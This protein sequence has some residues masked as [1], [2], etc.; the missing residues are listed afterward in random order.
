ML[1]QIEN[2]C[3][4]ITHL[5]VIVKLK[6]PNE[7]TL[8]S[9]IAHSYETLGTIR[10]YSIIFRVLWKII[11]NI[12]VSLKFD[13]QIWYISLNPKCITITIWAVRSNW[14]DSW[15]NWEYLTQLQKGLQNLK[16]PARVYGSE[17]VSGRFVYSIE[18]RLN[19]SDK[20][21]KCF[22]TDSQSAES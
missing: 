9:E 3:Q 4:C 16:H 15:N 20:L 19:F 8:S 1:I 18:T 11:A 10:W 22:S 17:R 12:S 2:K 13:I 7:T 5:I 14:D 6:Y 21:Y